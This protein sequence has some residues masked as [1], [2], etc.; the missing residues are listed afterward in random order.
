MLLLC[1][2]PEMKDFVEL[3]KEET[4]LPTRKVGATHGVTTVQ[5]MQ[6]IHVK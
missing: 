3:F 6:L 4:L 1:G 2:Q 5:V